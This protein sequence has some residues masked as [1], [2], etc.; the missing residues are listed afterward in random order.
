MHFQTTVENWTDSLVRMP[1]WALLKSV[2][3]PAILVDGMAKWAAAG[4][5][6]NRLWTD[7]R[8][9]DLYYP[10]FDAVAYTWE[11]LKVTW[12]MNFRRFIDATYLREYAQHIK[13]VEELNEYTDTRM[14][15]DKALLAPRLLSAQAAV[16]VWNNEYRGRV[17]EVD[18]V[19]G[20]IPA[21]CRLVICNSPVGNDVP[22][23]FYALSVAEDAPLGVHPY[24]HWVNGVRDPLDFRYHSGR[25]HYNEQAYGIKPNYVWTECGPYAGVLEGWR[26]QNV[27][28]GNQE[29]LNFGMADWW[30]DCQQTA[31]YK[32]GR[33]LGPGAW[34][35]SSI[36]QDQ[37]NYYRLYEPELT[38]LADLARQI[39]KIGTIP[40]P[41]PPPLPPPP[42]PPAGNLLINGSFENGTYKWGGVDEFNIP[43]DWDWTFAPPEETNPVDPSSWSEFKPPEVVNPSAVNLPPH[44]QALFIL[45]GE[46]TLKIFKGS[47][48]IKFSLSQLVTIT[49]PTTLRLTMPIYADL[50]KGYTDG[51]Q[52]VWADDSE[53][54]DG[55]YKWIIDDYSPS[56]WLSLVPGAWED[57]VAEGTVQPGVVRVGVEVMLP[58]PLVNNGIFADSWTLEA[59]ETTEPPPDDFAFALWVD[60]LAKQTASYNTEAALQA[61]IFA[62][63]F[64]PVMN[65]SRFDHAGQRYAEQAAEHLKIDERRVYFCL[66]GDW[67]NVQYITSPSTLAAAV[68][69]AF[70]AWP[71]NYRRYTQEFGARSEYYSQFG[72]PGHE[73]VDIR[74]PM[75]SPIYTVAP[76]VVSRVTNLRSNGQPSNYGWNV[77]VDHENGYETLY[78]HMSPNAIVEPGKRVDSGA[79]I[80]YSGNTGNSDA[81]HLHLTLYCISGGLPGYPGNIIDPTPFL[82]SLL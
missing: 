73:G 71:T 46:R 81:A 1:D 32:E 47:G 5:D 55:L 28:N 75:D 56:V 76:G 45:D 11:E 49:E 50:V 9:H 30:Q 24:T 79:I 74:A 78:A 22:K 29:L 41:P 3:D 72:F 57:I 17:R 43:D 19:E 14:I 66:E 38:P 10:Q 16:W 25:W 65:E 58:F 37:W 21:N 82:E 53:G 80:G 4:R 59:V 27:M 64:V 35:T 7:F 70:K 60:S 2:N 39:W 52:K 44:E 62:D 31:A 77:T 20:L 12:R 23:E 40:P 51:G 68:D 18:G 6:T 63:G 13:L 69:F 33:I 26:H 15:T 48:S 34:F 42:P 36:S 61:R 67:G 54:R 8:H